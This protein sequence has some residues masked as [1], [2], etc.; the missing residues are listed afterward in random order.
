MGAFRNG[1]L[2]FESSYPTKAFT[3]DA[4]IKE[5]TDMLAANGAW[6]TGTGSEGHRL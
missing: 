4:C 3:T 5:R 1:W 2:S 6:M